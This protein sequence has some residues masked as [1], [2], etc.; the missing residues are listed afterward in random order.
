MD[1]PTSL[2]PTVVLEIE[3]ERAIAARNCFADHA[4]FGRFRT[5]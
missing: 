3:D 1:R 2:R 5:G 4:P